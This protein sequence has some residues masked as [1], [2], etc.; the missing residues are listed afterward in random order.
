METEAK[1]LLLSCDPLYEEGMRLCSMGEAN[2]DRS[3][4]WQ[5]QQDSEH[6]VNRFIQETNLNARI[7][8]IADPYGKGMAVDS[9]GCVAKLISQAL[10]KGII[11]L[12]NDG[13]E[14]VYP[15]HSSDII[16]GLIKAMFSQS[17][18]AKMYALVNSEGI[19]LLS[20]ASSIK[21]YVPEIQ[22]RYLPSDSNIPRQGI[23]EA[24]IKSQSVLGWFPRFDID[25]G[26]GQ[27]IDWFRQFIRQEYD[28]PL[29]APLKSDA[30]QNLLNNLPSL[31]HAVSSTNELSQPSFWEKNLPS[32][33]AQ[34]N[35]TNQV[36]MFEKSGEVQVMTGGLSGK[37]ASKI[38]LITVQPP[39]VHFSVFSAFS[40]LLV[41]LGIKREESVPGH[42]LRFLI[43]SLLILIIIP[44][45]VYYLGATR[46]RQELNTRFN[47]YQNFN[48]NKQ[49]GV[50]SKLLRKT[51][52]VVSPMVSWQR[53]LVMIP[54]KSGEKNID[55]LLKNMDIVGM[56]MNG[57]YDNCAKLW[58][59]VVGQG[60]AD[61]AALQADNK[62]RLA[63]VAEQLL[64]MEAELKKDP[65]NVGV[66]GRVNELKTSTSYWQEFNQML[67]AL[68]SFT[69]RKVVA[70]AIQDSLELRPTGGFVD[71]IV[72]L[73]FDKGKLMD[74][75]T[76]SV[77]ELDAQ[78]KGLVKPPEEIAQ[79]IEKR[80]GEKQWWLRDANM[81]VD[82]PNKTAPRIA[83]F[84]NKQLGM[85]VDAVWSVDSFF[86]RDLL[87]LTGE[88]PLPDFNENISVDNFFDRQFKYAS[89]SLGSQQDT[90][91]S[92]LN[93]LIIG[94]GEKTKS[95]APS[96]VLKLMPFL[97][98]QS[99]S[100][101]FLVWNGDDYN[102]TPIEL[103]WGGGFVETPTE[104]VEFGKL[105]VSDYMN[106]ADANLGVNKA[107][108]FLNKSLSYDITFN[109]DNTNLVNLSYEL[110]NGSQTETWPA[111]SY[112]AQVWIYIPQSAS[113][114]KVEIK[115][116]GQ[117]TL[118]EQDDISI[119]P[120]SGKQGVGFYVEVAP[121][122]QRMIVLS[123]SLPGEISGDGSF[124]LYIQKPF[125][126][127]RIPLTIKLN[128]PSAWK[129][130]KLSTQ[131]KLGS[132][133]AETTLEIDSDYFFAV[134]FSR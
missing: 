127:D 36:D 88:I 92:F 105:N 9:C 39:I 130:G 27:S 62:T 69:K 13:M 85:P 22:I 112:K 73:T 53:G 24:M 114:K 58:G 19:S 93:A 63:R 94:V 80:L 29:I 70:V 120:E 86:I 111:G 83:W 2:M 134:S 14:V 123:Y 55:G 100:R 132:G 116:D 34:N 72:L 31:D 50:F 17:S 18:R 23:T 54:A 46:L 32:K 68:M 26:I 35:K 74:V 126:I 41:L 37:A 96:Q 110:K 66:L 30:D 11:S 119:S 78:M 102:G 106:V 81:F 65:E 104:V 64:Y 109:S 125:G 6:L 89:L 25:K 79:I 107:N 40:K 59:L 128:Y 67:P 97:S 91:K 44:Q 118:L 82:F 103:A 51:Y 3:V 115:S 117:S 71:T 47:D 129:I 131:A 45:A 49:I 95:L 4:Y 43:T 57:V 38:P 90:K 99:K 5:V 98:L 21:K 108:Y 101:H 42:L 60:N 87:K 124:G 7:V 48:K 28:V 122:S 33:P 121:Q 12:P 133:T 113:L 15:T 56:E 8:R 77:Y 84:L 20:L 75:Q 1:F 52:G 76:K 61:P 16:F 10:S